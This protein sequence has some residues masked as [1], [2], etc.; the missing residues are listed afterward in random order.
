M[1]MVSFKLRRSRTLMVMYYGY[2]AN[3]FQFAFYLADF[4]LVFFL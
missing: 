2:Y 4:R 1:P 3:G